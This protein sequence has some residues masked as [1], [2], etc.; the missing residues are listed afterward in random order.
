MTEPVILVPLD[1]SA[2]ALA[3]VPVAR[4]LCEITGASLRILHVCSGLPLPPTQL[5]ESLGLQD[6]SLPRSSIEAR[7][8]HPAAGVVEEAHALTVGTIVMCTHTAPHRPPTILG[9]TALDVLQAAPC[10]VVLVPPELAT[11]HWGVRRIVLPYDGSPVSHAAIGPAA[12]LAHDAGAELLVL[13]VGESGACAPVEPGSISMPL[14]VDQPQHE[15]PSWTG[16]LLER[17]ASQC[18]QCEFR[19]HLHVRG[20]EAGPEIVRLAAEHTADLIVL[21]WKGDWSGAHSATLKTVIRDAPC[22]V[23]VVRAEVE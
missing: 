20:G 4:A 13:Q 23:M 11:E 19:A 18:P 15:W 8:G 7:I 6:W 21:A 14:Y 3:A 12:R 22:P 5:I 1:G 10:P 9:R 16:E 17:L 2:H